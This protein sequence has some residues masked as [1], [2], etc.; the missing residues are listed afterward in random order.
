MSRVVLN[1]VSEIG[2][3]IGVISCVQQVPVSCS[4][5]VSVTCNTVV[6]S[7]STHPRLQTPD[8]VNK[9]MECP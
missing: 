7:E 1:C 5:N 8:M 3:P 6:V 2:S 9:L 4:L